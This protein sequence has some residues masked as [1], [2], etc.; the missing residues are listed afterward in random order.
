MVDVETSTHICV[1]Y[2]SKITDVYKS[3]DNSKADFLGVYL[4]WIHTSGVLSK[5]VANNATVYLGW[6]IIQHLK[7]LIVSMWEC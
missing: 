6:N 5:L 1:G 2:D 3:Q 4:D 7:V